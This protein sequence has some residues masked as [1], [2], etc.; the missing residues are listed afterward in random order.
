LKATPRPAAAAAAAAKAASKQLA[1]Q[2]RRTQHAWET[3]SEE[4]E[5]AAE[6]AAAAAAAAA[7]PAYSGVSSA[8]LVGALNT[9][10][11]TLSIG[12]G[13]F[14]AVVAG[15]NDD[16][17]VYWLLRAAGPPR[18][19]AAPLEAGGLTF[20]AG[21]YVV[22]GVWLERLRGRH[23]GPQDYCIGEPCAAYTHLVICTDVEVHSREDGVYTVT[24]HEDGRICAARR[25]AA[26]ALADA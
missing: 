10:L 2:G 1:S 26:L 17:D 11:E 23:A 22:E 20:E 18:Q 9:Q 6:A 24:M 7:Q 12:V 25:D 8:R 13:D 15:E 4:E 5:G 14:V 3:D 16:D 21:E 19:L